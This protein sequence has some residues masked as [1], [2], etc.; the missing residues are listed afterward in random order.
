MDAMAA[1]PACD[2]GVKVPF[3]IPNLTDETDKS[4]ADDFAKGAR[5]ILTR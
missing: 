2:R 5:T 3:E 1:R 4:A